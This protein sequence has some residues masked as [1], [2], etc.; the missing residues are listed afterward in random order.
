[1][2]DNVTATQ[3]ANVA[4]EDLCS[5]AVKLARRVQALDDGI[6]TITLVKYGDL[7]GVWSMQIEGED[8]RVEVLR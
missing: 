5:K 3:P 6:Y 2:F 1:M 8:G 4:P 7:A